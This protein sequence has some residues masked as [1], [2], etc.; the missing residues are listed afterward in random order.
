MNSAP[1]SAQSTSTRVRRERS[2]LKVTRSS[3]TSLNSVFLPSI[4]TGTEKLAYVNSICFVFLAVGVA[5][6]DPS[7]IEQKVPEP[8][9]EFMPA[10]IIQASEP[11]K[12]EPQLNRRNPNRSRHAGGDAADCDRRCRRPV[13]GKIRGAGR[14]PGGF[15]A[16]EVRSGAAARSAET[17][18]AN[19]GKNDGRG[20]RHLSRSKVSCLCAGTAATSVVTLII[21][22]KPDGSSSL[23]S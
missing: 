20:R 9:Q 6:L 21:G 3:P 7:K 19:G 1:I 5:G 4:A 10:E 15:C 13:S 2:T 11:P 12:V 17:G 14:R 8:I 18:D 22:V 23:W 16:R